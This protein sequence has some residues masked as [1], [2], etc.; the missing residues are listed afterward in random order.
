MTHPS[1]T[2]VIPWA[3]ARKHLTTEAIRLYRMA[4]RVT[5]EFERGRLA[6]QAEQCEILTNLPETLALL[7]EPDDGAR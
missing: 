7:E 6:G 2:Q 4:A 1:D 3:A 5:S